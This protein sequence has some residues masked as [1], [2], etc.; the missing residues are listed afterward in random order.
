MNLV[1]LLAA[2]ILSLNLAKTAPILVHGYKPT[3]YLS[4]LS[5]FILNFLTSAQE[6]QSH[7]QLKSHQE[8]FNLNLAYLMRMARPILNYDIPK[9]ELF[10]FSPNYD[11]Q[12][13]NVYK[14]YSIQAK[15]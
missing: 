12:T 8:N 13:S 11:Y 9:Y 3:N 1:L 2:F 5:D 4:A 10:T 7:K 15:Y 14:R 6:E